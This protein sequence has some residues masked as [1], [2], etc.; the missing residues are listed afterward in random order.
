[1]HKFTH[2]DALYQVARYIE[3]MN[4][5]PECPEK[6]KI[7]TP[8]KYRGTV[9][10]HGTNAGV[11]LTA[12]SNPPEPQDL[13]A[14]SRTRALE[15]GKNDNNGF[16]QFVHYPTGERETAFRKIEGEVRQSAGIAKEATVVLYGEWIGPGVQGSVAIGKLPDKQFVLF[17]VKVFEAGADEDA[18][19]AYVA[20]PALGDR[21]AGLNIFSIVDGPTWEL[22]IDFSSEES[23]Q[24]ALDKAEE[25][26]QA[27]EGECPW[28]ARFGIQGMG[29]GIVW[30]PVGDHWG[31]SDLF[32]KTKG[33]KH[34]V[35]KSK[36]DRPSLAPEVVESIDGFVE[37]AV[38]E[39]RLEQGLEA[40]QEAGHELSQ[41]GI[42]PYLAWVSK[43]VQREC[44]L[45]LEGNEL[46]WKQVSRAVTKKARDFYIE[47]TQLYAV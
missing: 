45:E 18:G 13:V 40:V 36:K 37:F 21:F 39:N 33:V 24:A 16:A 22:E 31:V 6:H 5:N 1:M 27:V 12:E 42:G 34:K 29:E 41:K 4:A 2:I 7:R 8:V 30:T 23:R 47:R 3:I 43:D 44:A 10:L 25:L 15:V 19:G 9:K 46:T 38:T 26:T 28:A 35:T 20:V 14:Q 32:F 17:A 11:A